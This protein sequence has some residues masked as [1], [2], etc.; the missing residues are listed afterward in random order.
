MLLG[1]VVLIYLAAGSMLKALMMGV[2]GLLLS[3]IA[4]T[5]FGHPAADLRH[6]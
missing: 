6:P 2:F 5:A 3:T 1:M 4:W